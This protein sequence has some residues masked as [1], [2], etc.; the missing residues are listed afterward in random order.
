[1]RVEDIQTGM[2]L[3]WQ[4]TTWPDKTSRWIV[5]G[6]IEK[7][8]VEGKRFEIFCIKSDLDSGPTINQSTTYVFHLGNIHRF[9]VHSQI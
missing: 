2:I 1:M 9:S 4:S 3:N 5:L 6:Q 8:H 7:P